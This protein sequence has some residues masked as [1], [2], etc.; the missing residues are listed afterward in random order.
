LGVQPGV[1]LRHVAVLMLSGVVIAAAWIVCCAMCG[2]GDALSET[3]YK[4]ERG[5]PTAETV[6]R[7]YDDADL[8]GGAGV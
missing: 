5:F 7:A 8:P 4:F 2:S 6:Q 1:M 3:S